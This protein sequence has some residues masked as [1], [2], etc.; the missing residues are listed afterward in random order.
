MG[1]FR[2]NE[3]HRFWITLKVTG[4]QYV[5]TG[6][7]SIYLLRRDRRLSWPWCYLYTENRWFNSLTSPSS[8]HLIWTRPGVEPM[9]SRSQVGH[10]TVT[11]PSHFYAPPYSL[12]CRVK[13]YYNQVVYL[14]IL[15]GIAR[16]HRRTLNMKAAA[17]SDRMKLKMPFA[18]S[19]RRFV[20]L[21]TE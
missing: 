21:R 5:K 15:C 12:H 3:N 14:V 1:F 10:P 16:T 9:T 17:A 8:N 11:P 13:V 2:W 20:V 7:Y 19:C 18:D 6:R 4:G